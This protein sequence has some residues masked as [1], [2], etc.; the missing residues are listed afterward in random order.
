MNQWVDYLLYVS[1][2][3]A[4]KYFEKKG[5]YIYWLIILWWGLPWPV[6]S[7]FH[8]KQCARIWR[9]GPVPSSTL[10]ILREYQRA[11]PQ[12]SYEYRFTKQTFRSGF[13]WLPSDGPSSCDQQKK[14]AS[15]VSIHWCLVISSVVSVKRSFRTVI[16]PHNLECLSEYNL[17]PHCCCVL[18]ST[19]RHAIREHQI[20]VLSIVSWLH[21]PWSAAFRSK[22]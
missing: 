20:Y 15:V 22:E 3:Y 4:F 1:P 19:L 11:P 21:I 16:I 18:S 17:R 9:Y 13:S 12:S 6:S 7:S 8:P 5:R 14:S 10:R 2:V